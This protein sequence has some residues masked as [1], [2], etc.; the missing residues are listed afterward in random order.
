[1]RD[2][3]ALKENIR[4]WGYE[5]GFT[6]IGFAGL[7]LGEAEARL[8]AWLAAGR[9]G[10][11]DY[12]AAHGALR[13][14]PRE[15]APFA[16]SAIICR[17]DYNGKPIDSDDSKCKELAV[18]ARYAQGRDYHNVMRKRL[19]RLAKRIETEVGP[20]DHRACVDSAPVME[21]ELARLAGLGWRGKHTLL[22]SRT[23]S[24]FFLGELLVSLP[25]P[26]DEPIADHCGRCAR[27]LIACPTQAFVAPFQL[28][29][30]RCIAYL[31][32]EHKGPIPLELRPRMGLHVFGCDICQE[33]CPW[34][35]FAP[36]GAPEFSPRAGLNA[37]R[38]V[39]LFAWSEEEFATRFTGS[40]IRR[41]G[42]ERWL[43]NLA[44][45]LGNAAPSQRIKAALA[46]RLDHPSALVREHVRWALSRHA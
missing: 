32:I 28:D 22:V 12:M 11:M 42:Y 18:I 40:P 45:A 35:R 8:M 9:H 38:L 1:M 39:E 7:E 16:K 23:G 14:H 4:A 31:T 17:L 43:R 27:C 33:V 2:W 20:C 41:I 29:A 15:F 37:A 46:S 5:L 24:W 3:H 19:A 13:A 34:N 10:E 25:L 30:R 36:L 21:V 44:V 26:P 6:A